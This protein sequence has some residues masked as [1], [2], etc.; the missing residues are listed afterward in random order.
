[1]SLLRRRASEVLNRTL[2]FEGLDDGVL[3]APLL[4]RRELARIVE[5]GAAP[6]ADVLRAA[7]AASTTRN[8][9]SWRLCV[10]CHCIHFR[11]PA[12]RLLPPSRRSD[13]LLPAAP[14]T[15]LPGGAAVSR[16]AGPAL[17]SAVQ[18][19]RCVPFIDAAAAVNVAAAAALALR[20][21]SGGAA[22]GPDLSGGERPSPPSVAGW[23]AAGG[24]EAAA[25]AAGSSVALTA[26]LLPPALFPGAATHTRAV[27]NGLGGAASLLRPVALQASP[28]L[29]GGAGADAIEAARPFAE[30]ARR[31]LCGACAWAPL[32]L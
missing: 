20:A 3:D 15:Q 5:L 17:V 28:E 1:M 16:R 32:P 21:I 29:Q 27:L 11:R 30:R 8:P 13:S 18:S 26:G 31:V 19:G 22:P 10:N 14:L 23:A 9:D 4:S 25:A 2:L 6:L 24:I 7:N 12:T